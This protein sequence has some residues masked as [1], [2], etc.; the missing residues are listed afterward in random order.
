M[1]NFDEA[2]FFD[3]NIK[4]GNS[5][6][7]QIVTTVDYTFSKTGIRENVDAVINYKQ[8][9]GSPLSGKNVSYDI[10]LDYRN[11]LKG[12]G[13]TDSSGNL[14]IKFTNAQPFILKSGHIKTRIKI[15]EKAFIAKT[16]PVKATSNEIDVQ[17]FPESGQL[18]NNLRSKVAFKATAASGLGEAVSGYVVNDL[19]EKV[20]DFTSEYAGMG[21]FTFVPLENKRYTAV[22][23]F[24]DGSEKRIDLPKATNQ[25][26]VLSVNTADPQNV[27]LKVSAQKGNDNSPEEL[28]VLAQSNG[29]VHYISKKALE[30]NTLSAI[31]SIPKSRFPA[32]VVHFTL[33]NAAFEP[34]AER[35]VFIRN[36]PALNFKIATE[37]ATYRKREKVRMDFTATD[38]TNNPVLGAFSV[39]VTDET[40]LPFNDVNET[41]ILSNLLLTSELKGFIETPNYYFTDINAEKERAL[42]NLMLTQGWR[43]FE[44]K[45]IRQGQFPLLAFRPETGIGISGQV[46]TRNG[47][48]VAG[49]K[50]SLLSSQGTGM[51]LDTLTDKQGRFMFDNLNFSDST[52]VI[53]R[54]RTANDRTN[55]YVDLDRLPPQVVTKNPNAA[56]SEINVNQSLYAYLNNRNQQFEEMRKTGLF[57]KS[58]IL[59]EVKIVDTK[60]KVKQSSNLN[61]AGN[62]DAILVAS[63]LTTCYNLSFCLQGRVSGVVIQSGI[64]YLT[65]NLYTYNSAPLPMLLVVDGVQVEPTYLSIINPLEVETIEVLKN[66]GNITIY[67]L[68]GSGGV[69][70]ITT[71]R[72]SFTG[73]PDS[74]PQGFASFKPQG[75]YY[76]RKFYSPKY[77]SPA[78]TSIPDW[79]STIFWEPNL[80]TGPDGKTSIEFYAAAKPGTY[81]AVV[82]GLDINGSLVRQVYR[83]NVE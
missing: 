25:G 27:F 19:N 60:P 83:F 2:Y 44:W 5:F 22:L 64:A 30:G 18:V 6:S 17:F 46:V 70:I 43:K 3:K 57:R 7:H 49:G 77:D 16:F 58:L 74:Y 79:R 40:Q 41:T 38:S 35:L 75:Y 4:V 11:I 32:G 48:P 20:T 42:D 76:S 24:K 73:S 37:K 51:A 33:F 67:G 62:A 26:Y 47:T 9:N 53:V 15:D 21:S 39:S 10:Q 54:A 14:R 8:L 72:G 1:R 81:K 69:L 61:G 34:L 71:K 56:S 28:T 29:V 13:V 68:N 50:V 52:S 12:T 78:S 65:R 45:R 63:D 80:L 66:I 55:V 31:A 36:K 82:E 23:K 59:E